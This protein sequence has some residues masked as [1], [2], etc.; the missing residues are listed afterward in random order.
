MNLAIVYSGGLSKCAYQ[1]GF[2]RAILKRIQKSDVKMVSGASLGI[3][4]A[5]ALSCGKLPVVEEMF[6]NI[7]VPKRSVLARRMIFGHLLADYMDSLFRKEDVLSIPVCFPI[8]LI[9]I[10]DVHYYWIYGAYNPGWKR[11]VNGAMSFPFLHILPRFIDGKF[12]VDGGG[13]DNIPI[14]PVLKRG[15]EFLPAGEKLDLIL[16]LHFDSHYDYR[17]DF[18][19]NVPVI[20]IDVAISNNFKK[21]HFNFSHAYVEEMMLCAEEYG[22]KICSRIFTG[23]VSREHFVNVRDEIFV[24]EYEARLRHSSADGFISFINVLGKALRRD[25][26]C[27]RKLF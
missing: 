2:T 25:S 8:C 26:K 24:E 12:A 22:D 20:D 9:P 23:D 1:L 4:S 19:T 15:N 13:V 10:V 7:D 3:F 21:N 16:A 14:Y 27:V 5:Y 18:N 11:Y 6:L 17:K